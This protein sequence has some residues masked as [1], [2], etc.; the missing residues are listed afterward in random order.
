MRSL[1]KIS[2]LFIYLF[3]FFMKR[4][5]IQKKHKKQISDFYSTPKKYKKANK[6]LSLIK[7]IKCLSFIL[8]AFKKRQKDKWLSFS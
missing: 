4:F 8:D 6:R 1:V 3:I 2:G 7:S 5:Y